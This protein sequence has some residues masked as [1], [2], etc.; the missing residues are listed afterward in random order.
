MPTY[1][2][3]FRVYRGVLYGVFLAFTLA[4]ITLVGRSVWLDLYGKPTVHGLQAERPTVAACAEE[5]DALNRE[6][7]ARLNMTMAPSAARDRDRAVAERDW[8]RQEADW[9]G[10][11]RGF[12]D[13]LQRVRARCVDQELPDGSARTAH[14]L[15]A[16]AV[17]ELD[18]LRQHLARC[19]LEGERER[20]SVLSALSQLQSVAHGS[21]R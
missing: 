10:F 19:G 12:E 4:F 3:E 14:D 5:L 11:T 6:L 7:D 18:D 17:D 16:T 13:R 15:M 9:N 1:D 8:D 21:P 2:P 20:E